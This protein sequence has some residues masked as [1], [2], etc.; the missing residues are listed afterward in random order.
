MSESGGVCYTHYTA[1]FRCQ[2]PAAAGPWSSPSLGG[3]V[4]ADRASPE[5]A[6]ARTAA[7]RRRRRR[8][9]LRRL[10]WPHIC[11]PDTSRTKNTTTAI[12]P[13]LTLGCR[14][15]GLMFKVPV[16]VGVNAVLLSR[17]FYKKSRP[18]P[19]PWLNELQYT[20][21]SRPWSRDHNTW[22]SG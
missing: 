4:T 19:R 13:W 12:C 16:M 14:V 3:R 2:S 5:T 8:R 1:A 6:T 10:T 17:P 20:R 22:Y 15:L 21:V 18:R 9:R 11:S 7:C